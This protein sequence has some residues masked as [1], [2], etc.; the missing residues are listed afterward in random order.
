MGRQSATTLGEFPSLASPRGPLHLPLEES[1][2]AL[3]ALEFALR[4]GSEADV[5]EI[6]GMPYTY[7]AV[8]ASAVVI[9]RS[10]FS[11]SSDEGMQRAASIFKSY[12]LEVSFVGQA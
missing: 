12:G 4:L 10:Q 9:Q 5:E 2:I 1:E 11:A 3:A 7:S 8:C 6:P